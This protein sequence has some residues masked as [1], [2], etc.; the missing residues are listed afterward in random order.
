[1]RKIVQGRDGQ[2]PFQR[3]GG[4]PH[5]RGRTNDHPSSLAAT[6]HQQLSVPGFLPVCSDLRGRRGWEWGLHFLLLLPGNNCRHQRP[7][8]SERLQ[9]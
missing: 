5:L 6:E 2:P 9:H 7:P 1:M 8:G 3:K 4:R